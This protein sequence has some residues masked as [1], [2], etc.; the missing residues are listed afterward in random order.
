VRPTVPQVFDW[1][2]VIVTE[3]HEL[4]FL[5][6]AGRPPDG[7]VDQTVPDAHIIHQIY[8]DEVLA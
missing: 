3:R 8:R 7:E 2:A 5:G 1:L 6:H 4:F